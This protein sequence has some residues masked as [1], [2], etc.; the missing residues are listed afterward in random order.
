LILDPRS[1]NLDPWSSILEP[2]SCTAKNWWEYYHSYKFLFFPS[3]SHIPTGGFRLN[4]DGQTHPLPLY[5]RQCHR[6]RSWKTPLKMTEPK[7]YFDFAMATITRKVHFQSKVIYQQTQHVPQVRGFV[8]YKSTTT[9]LYHKTQISKK[10][11]IIESS[12]S[13]V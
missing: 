9:R 11:K 12:L 3:Q 4:H 7:V 10:W 8:N 2:W 5:H 1:L 6:E 13:G